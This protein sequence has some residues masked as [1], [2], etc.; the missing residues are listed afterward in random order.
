MYWSAAQIVAH[1]SSNGC[2]LRPGDILGSGTISGPTPDSVGSM[3][4]LTLGGKQPAK[5]AGGE[6]RQFLENGDE[7]TERAKCIRDGF[8]A[9]GFGSCSGTIRA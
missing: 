6:T 2:N 7:V 4:E 5:L 8:A 3:L 9:I 1:H